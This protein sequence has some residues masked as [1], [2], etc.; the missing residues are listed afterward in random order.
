MSRRTDR[1]DSLV[2]Q[3]LGQLLLTKLSDP[4]IDP[5]RTTI[6]NV[7]VSEDLTSAKVYVSVIGPEADQRKALAALKHAAGHLQELMMREVSLRQTPVL[8]F[9]LDTDFKKALETMEIIDQAMAEIRSREQ[10]SLAQ[11]D[12]DNTHTRN[13]A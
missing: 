6:T 12:A 11:A 5:A 1:V 13:D 10:D 9:V 3:T 4:R 2:R 7:A 8:N